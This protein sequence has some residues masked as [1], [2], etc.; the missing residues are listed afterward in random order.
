MG[1][2]AKK[3]GVIERVGGLSVLAFM[4]IKKFPKSQFL[5]KRGGLLY[6]IREEEN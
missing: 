5:T 6:F 3:A 4:L 1:Q 2:R